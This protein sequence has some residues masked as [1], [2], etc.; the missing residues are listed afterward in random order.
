MTD[1]IY[2]GVKVNPNAQ[3]S[4]TVDSSKAELVYRGVKHQAT[5]QEDAQQTSGIYRGAKWKGG[6]EKSRQMR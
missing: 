1:N 2:R 5:Q 4:Q 3:Q 6:T